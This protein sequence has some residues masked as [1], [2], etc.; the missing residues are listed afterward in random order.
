M[1]ACTHSRCIQFRH[2]L[3][4]VTPS[5]PLLG[6][7]RSGVAGPAGLAGSDSGTG[8]PQAEV[9]GPPFGDPLAQAGRRPWSRPVRSTAR[10]GLQG[11]IAT[12]IDFHALHAFR[13]R[14]DFDWVR[15]ISLKWLECW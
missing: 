5:C 9:A 4:I 15:P 13:F 11:A 12:L 10:T 7:A 2:G 8:H 6:S 14:F 3:G 1:G